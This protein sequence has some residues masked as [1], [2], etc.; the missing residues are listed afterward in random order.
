LGEGVGEPGGELGSR[1]WVTSG[2]RLV[3]SVVAVGRGFGESE[4]GFGGRGED[5]DRL[6][7]VGE[8]GG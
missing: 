6:A 8:K 3:A 4:G 1:R 2:T 5:Q 7:D